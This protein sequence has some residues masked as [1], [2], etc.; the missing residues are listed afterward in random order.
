MST[1]DNTLGTILCRT[2]LATID[3]IVGAYGL[4]ARRGSVPDYFDIVSGGRAMLQDAAVERDLLAMAFDDL[5]KA[6]QA[7]RLPPFTLMSSHTASHR[8]DLAQ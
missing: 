8:S 1:F 5:H 4:G 3:A 6:H 7:G 2:D